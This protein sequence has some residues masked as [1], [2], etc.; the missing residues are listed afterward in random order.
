MLKGTRAHG[1]L[2]VAG[3]GLEA[4]P[5][6]IL[7]TSVTSRMKI[8][9][10]SNNMLE[11]IPDEFVQAPRMT[12][13]N[14]STNRLE[15][16]PILLGKETPK[17]E[18]LD[19]HSNALLRSLPRELPPMLREINISGCP[20]TEIPGCVLAC[21]RLRHLSANNCGISGLPA[22]LERL[23]KLEQLHLDDNNIQSLAGVKSWKTLKGLQVVSLRNNR[24]GSADG[25]AAAVGGATKSSLRV[26]LPSGLFLDTALHMLRLDGN[27]LQSGQLLDLEGFDAFLQRRK[28]RIDKSIGAGGAADAEA[29]CGVE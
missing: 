4:L 12:R 8:V 23:G 16:L 9:D 28:Q 15:A 21:A 19:L 18:V 20:L 11:R 22:G 7:E 3:C 27:G 29:I 14:A 1:G 13:L 5:S 17:L 10:I 26:A 6:Q 25:G 2:N 24:I